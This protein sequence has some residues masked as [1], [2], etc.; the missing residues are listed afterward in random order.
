[1]PEITIIFA[2][3]DF[4]VGFSWDSKLRQLHLFPIPMVGLL[5]QFKVVPQ[6]PV[7]PPV[8]EWFEWVHGGKGVPWR[9]GTEE[10]NKMLAQG[11]E[12]VDVT[13][14]ATVLTRFVPK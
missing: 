9:H 5:F 12:I 14:Y 7:E 3:F 6:T 11:W 1:M 10:F 2:W 4:W 13:G 8:R